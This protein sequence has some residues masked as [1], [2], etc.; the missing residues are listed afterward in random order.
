[1]IECITDRRLASRLAL[2]VFGVVCFSMACFN[3]SA[4]GTVEGVGKDIQYAS[5]KTAEALNGDK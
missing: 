5:E 3:L 1:M 4:C 2:S